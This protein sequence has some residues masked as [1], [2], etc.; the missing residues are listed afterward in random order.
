MGTRF[1]CTT[2]TLWHRIAGTL[3]G[4]RGGETQNDGGS[5]RFGAVLMNGEAGDPRPMSPVLHPRDFGIGRLFDRVRDA[6][7]VAEAPS[8]RI[9][10]WN[11]AAEA[12]FGY[13][14]TEALSLTVDVLVPNRLQPLHRAGIERFAATGHGRIVDDHRAIEVTAR[15]RSGEER[16]VEL[17]LS[18]LDSPFDEL[19][20]TGR[21]VLAIM[22]DVSIRAQAVAEQAARAAAEAE[23]QRLAFLAETSALLASSLDYRSTL[24]QVVRLAVPAL[25]DGC[26]ADLIDARG[27]IHRLAT[28]SADPARDAVVRELGVRYPVVT[29]APAGSAL[30]LR[31]GQPLLYNDDEIDTLWKAI[32]RDEEHLALLRRLDT[33]SRMIV[34]LL[35]RGQAL[36]VLSFSLSGQDRRYGTADL[37][38]AEELARRAALA[39]DN[40]RLYESL[41]LSEQRFRSFVQK[42][43]DVIVVLGPDGT[44]RYASPPLEKVLGYRPEAIIGARTASLVHP[45]DRS[46]VQEVVRVVVQDPGHSHTIEMRL[47]HADGSWR[48]L[49]V[50]ATNLFGDPA[51]QGVVIN[52]HDIT[53]RKR[54]EEDERF[55]S[56]AGAVLATS[57]D[58]DTTL[59]QLLDLTVPRLGDWCAID[60]LDRDGGLRRTAVACQDPE[61]A[62]ALT[63]LP[64]R[65]P[66]DREGNHPAAVALRTGEPVIVPDFSEV[67][68]RVARSEEH[69]ALMRMIR[70]KSRIS[71]PLLVRGERLG[72]L[73]FGYADSGRRHDQ[74]DVALASRFADRATLAIKSAHLYHEAQ[75]A[76]AEVQR[77]LSLR[78]E[79][80]SVASHELRT[81]LTALKGQI[82]LAE[83]RL[84][85]GQPDAV[86][87][88]IQHADAQIDRLARL[89]RDLLDVSRI[90]GG[91]ITIE[92]QPV[93]LGALVQHVVDLERAA[94]SGREFVVDLP[95]TI[96][97]IYADGQRIE[98]VLFN[99]LQNARKYSPPNTPIQVTVRV[100]DDAVSIAVT[101]RGEGIPQ[102]DLPRIFD[103]FHRA[104]NVDRNIAG[105]GLGLYITREIVQAHG[106]SLTVESTLGQGS[107]FTVT[108]PLDRASDREPEGEAQV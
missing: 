68:T 60:V 38:L 63:E 2:G 100:V 86:P 11:P 57:L 43:S 76:L 50:S 41:S 78:D 36:G 89:V 54:S 12:L 37:A 94:A 17:T 65:Y 73:S 13:S 26:A 34:P 28:A 3:G 79:F 80:L 6:V 72:V 20:S 58:Y 42:A 45:E 53:E 5:G 27:V 98:Q 46:R 31:T 101:D 81:P 15:T 30:A 1:A 25:A 70:T 40:A 83:R 47:R 44:V 103:R 107:T 69:L 108:L 55:L 24:T 105:L 51:V 96:P 39:I 102:E 61:I 22:R 85:R 91:G 75:A 74:R 97:S 49:E 48:S 29:D 64:R 84:R 104:G 99:L 4:K 59:G 9:R 16:P 35:S 88:L 21:F 14:A 7:V 66:I 19:P 93:A 56:E 82:Q 92:R 87:T 33:T 32:A 77:A 62:Q 52:L 10:L 106:G 23:Q 67:M 18:P 8:G 90:G 71:V 95:D